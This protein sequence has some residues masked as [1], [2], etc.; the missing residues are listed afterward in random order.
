ML[1]MWYTLQ[2]FQMSFKVKKVKI[3]NVW[4]YLTLWFNSIY[5]CRFHKVSYLGLDCDLSKWKFTLIVKGRNSYE[6]SSSE[7]FILV[8]QMI[9]RQLFK[10]VFCHYYF[11]P[12]C[13]ISKI[14][15]ERLPDYTLSNIF[16]YILLFLLCLI[17]KL[18]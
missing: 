7:E 17:I 14:P 10:Y 12:I 11:L 18:F 13:F 2:F 16:T 3:N 8:L 6:K 15:Y 4:E 1:S 9:I 5:A